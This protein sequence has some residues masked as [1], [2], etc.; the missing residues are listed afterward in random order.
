MQSSQLNIDDSILKLAGRFGLVA[1][2]L[3]VLGIVALKDV[4]TP[5]KM[6]GLDGW[7]Q[8]MPD[9]P[10]ATALSAVAFVFA[11]LTMI[12]WAWGIQHRDGRAGVKLGA[13]SITLGA[14]MNAVAC[15]VP[16]VVVTHFLPSC[17]DAAA[18]HPMARALLGYAI[19]MDGHVASLRGRVASQT[20][21]AARAL[22]F[23]DI[24]RHSR[25]RSPGAPSNR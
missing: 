23:D 18:C 20:G 21:R 14:L 22:E 13:L 12:P 11:V 16:F 19:T 15:L 6:G 4:T 5:Y 25:T 7:I 8:S 1:V 3:N 9:Y 24:S 17:D 10:G 2:V